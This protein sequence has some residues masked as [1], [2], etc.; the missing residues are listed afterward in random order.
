MRNCIG[1]NAG[2]LPGR[3]KNCDRAAQL[4]ALERFT[5]HAMGLGSA[6]QF[7][8]KPGDVDCDVINGADKKEDTCEQQKLTL[9]HG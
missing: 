1:D 7:E 6:C 4:S 3:N 2:F 9:K 8:P 5:I